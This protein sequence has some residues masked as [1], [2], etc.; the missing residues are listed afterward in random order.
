MKR[1]NTEELLKFLALLGFTIYFDYLLL[2]D[3]IRIFISPRM[4]K[5]TVFALII[6]TILTIYQFTKIFTIKSPFPI[7]KSYIIMFLTLLIGINGIKVGMNA[8]LGNNKVAS[9]NKPK[10]NTQKTSSD[11]NVNKIKEVVFSDDNYATLV[12]DIQNNIKKYKGVNISINGCVY[13]DSTFKDNEFAVGRLMISCCVA[14]AELVGLTCVYSNAN[15]IKVNSWIKVEGILEYKNNV[16]IV[17]VRNIKTISK[18][19]NVYIYPM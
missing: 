6:F 14:D 17:K 15:N 11:N 9:V 3:K 8:N 18:P 10:A 1:F 19:E 7:D 5:Y 16:P 4:V 13:K 2:T 12:F